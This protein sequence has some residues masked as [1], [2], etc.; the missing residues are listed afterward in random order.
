MVILTVTAIS[1]R[2]VCGTVG[3]VLD[4]SQD[5]RRHVEESNETAVAGRDIGQG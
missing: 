3:R 5:D 2:R 4:Y 1:G